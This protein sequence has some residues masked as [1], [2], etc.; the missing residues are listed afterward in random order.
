MITG[1]IITSSG[2]LIAQKLVECNPEINYKRLANMALYGCIICGGLGH[3]WF[4]G[5]DSA[6]GSKQTI[7]ATLKKMGVDLVIFAPPETM[8]FMAWAHQSTDQSV[9]IFDKLKKDFKNVL[10][11]DYLLWVPSQFVNF[12][13]VPERHRVLFQSVI[14][15]FWS[16]FISYAT[17]NDLGAFAFG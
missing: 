16:C 9:S 10:I 15:V 7:K 2:D 5:L 4:K 6:F 3:Y 11:A 13:L 1:T 12:L 8:L 14:M 17:H